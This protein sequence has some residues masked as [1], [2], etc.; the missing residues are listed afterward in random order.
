[1]TWC[2]LQGLSQVSC[3]APNLSYEQ[4]VETLG[5]EL[6]SDF[7]YVWGSQSF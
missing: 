1:M 6:G 7:F 5:K 2:H 3:P 4:L